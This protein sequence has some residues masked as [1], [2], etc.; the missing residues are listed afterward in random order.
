MGIVGRDNLCETAAEGV[1]SSVDLLINN[2]FI[3]VLAFVQ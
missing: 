2:K 3:R 1:N